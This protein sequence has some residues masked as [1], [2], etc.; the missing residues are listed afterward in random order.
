MSSRLSLALVST[1]LMATLAAGSSSEEVLLN[2]AHSQEG[3][4]RA[5]LAADT[6]QQVLLADPL[7]PEALAGLARFYKLAGKSEEA[8]AYLERLR[9][10]D[11]N[12]PAIKDIEAISA[13]TPAQQPKLRE[14]SRL[15]REQK[16]DEAMRLFREVFGDQPPAGDWS[17]AYYETEAAHCRRM[18]SRGRT[19]ARIVAALS[20]QSGIQAFVGALAE[21][22]P[23]VPG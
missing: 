9:K 10:V 18:G 1:L 7:Q 17:I 12:Y 16:F 4:G 11:P 3:R 15:A 13:I 14:A 6:W 5:D 20:R 23:G 19:P 8:R 21:L 22:S 2:K